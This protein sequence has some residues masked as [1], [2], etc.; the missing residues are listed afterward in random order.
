MAEKRVPPAAARL[1]VKEDELKAD[2]SSDDMEATKSEALV[3]VVITFFANTQGREKK[4]EDA[5]KKPE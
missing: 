2:V 5:K 1:S 3:D 4:S